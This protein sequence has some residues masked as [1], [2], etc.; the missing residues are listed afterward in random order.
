MDIEDGDD[1]DGSDSG[2]DGDGDGNGEGHG[3]SHH[4]VRAFEISRPHLVRLTTSGPRK[5][6]NE[7]CVDPW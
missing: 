2:D 6:Q 4:S 7:R 3:S 5:C 1:D